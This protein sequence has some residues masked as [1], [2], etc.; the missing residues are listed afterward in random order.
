MSPVPFDRRPRVLEHDGVVEGQ[1]LCC[2]V[3]VD[4]QVAVDSNWQRSPGL[5]SARLG[6]SLADFAGCVVPLSVESA[7]KLCGIGLYRPFRRIALAFVGSWGTMQ[8][9]AHVTMPDRPVIPPIRALRPMVS[10]GGNWGLFPHPGL[11]VFTVLTLVLLL[12]ER[13]ESLS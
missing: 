13:A 1:F 11:G 8:V 2:R 7:D 5:T 10:H 6:S 3:V 9:F 12:W 4:A